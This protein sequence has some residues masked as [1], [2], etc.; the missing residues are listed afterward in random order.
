[1]HEL[2]I[3]KQL[4]EKIKN[5]V[6]ENELSKKELVAFVEL[7]RL[8]TFSQ[9]PM[10]HYYNLIAKDDK[11]LSKIKLII[12]ITEGKIEC[13]NCGCKKIIFDFFDMFCPNCN[14]PNTE[15]IQGRDVYLKKI[16]KS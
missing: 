1:M 2:E 13:T 8:S 6:K 15:I 5:V 4:A 16:E 14:S 12:E 9:E 10:Q 7:G 11:I 3:T